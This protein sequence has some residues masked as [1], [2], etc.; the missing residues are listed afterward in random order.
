MFRW[1]LNM[2][3]AAEK[4]RLRWDV[5]QTA[6]ELDFPAEEA[7]QQLETVVEWGRYAE[8]LAYDDDEEMLYLEPNVTPMAG[9]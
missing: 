4:Q 7:Q 9:S 5:I 3:R 1:L 8:I 2:L 6:L